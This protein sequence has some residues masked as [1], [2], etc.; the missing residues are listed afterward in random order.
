MASVLNKLGLNNMF[1]IM[2]N[3]AIHKTPDVY[4]AVRDHEHTPL[5]LPPYSPF[6]NPI[7]ECWSKI[8]GEVRKTL[9]GKSLLTGLKKQPRKLHQKTV[10]VGFVIRKSI[11]LSV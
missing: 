3:A 1:V 11:S 10:K 7:E 9:L 8:K 4:K 2:D 6:L 5:F